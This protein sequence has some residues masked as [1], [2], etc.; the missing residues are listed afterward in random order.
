MIKQLRYV[1]KKLQDHSLIDEA[2]QQQQ[3][4]QQPSGS[5]VSKVSKSKNNLDKN[6]NKSLYVAA[7]Y[8]VVHV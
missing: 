7:I 5:E 8:L 2:S 6:N 1:T 4:Q 3:R